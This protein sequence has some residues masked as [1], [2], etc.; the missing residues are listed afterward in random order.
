[1]DR[2][3]VELVLMDEIERSNTILSR[4]FKM[5]DPEKTGFINIKDLKFILIKSNHLTQKEINAII[6]NCANLK[7]DKDKFE[8]STFKSALFNARYQ[9]AKAQLLET[10]LDQT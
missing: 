10:N 6:R 3:A 2:E 1:M 7:A 5:C 9:L 4:R 8:Y